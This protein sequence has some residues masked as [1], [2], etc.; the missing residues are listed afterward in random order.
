[1]KVIYDTLR[2]DPKTERL[3]QDKLKWVETEGMTPGFWNK[4]RADLAELLAENTIFVETSGR[5]KVV[6]SFQFFVTNSALTVF[7]QFS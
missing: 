5:T 6:S 7:P 4:A 3:I 2:P 1:V